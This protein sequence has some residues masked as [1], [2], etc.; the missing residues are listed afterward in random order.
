MGH[1]IPAFCTTPPW[2]MLL[3]H[4]AIGLIGVVVLL[5][6]LLPWMLP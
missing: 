4:R 5:L 2:A 3:P 1:V 6:L